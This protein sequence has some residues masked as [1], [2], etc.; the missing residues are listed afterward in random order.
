MSV[1]LDRGCVTYQ[2]DFVWQGTRYRG[3]THQIRKDDAELVEAQIKLKLRQ[4][5]G[6]IAPF[7]P[8]DTPRFTDWAEVYLAYQKKH[9]DRP[10]TIKRTLL[11]VLEFWGAKPRTAKRSPAVTRARTVQ[12]PYHNLHL[13]H[14]IADPSWLLRFERWIEAR[15]VSTSTRN[16]YLSA[17]S[18]MYRV[19]MQPEYR[20]DTGITEN[21]FKEIRRGRGHSREV[22]LDAQTIVRW[23]QEAGYHVALATTIAALAPKLRLGTIL[24]LRWDEHIDPNLRTITV[25]RHKTSRRTGRPQV[26]PISEQLRVVLADARERQHAEAVRRTRRRSRRI[27]DSG[28]VVTWRGRPV[29]SIKKACRRAVERIGLTWGVRDGV[30]FHTIRHSIATL[31][32]EMGLPEAIRKELL[33]HTEIRTTQRYTHLAAKA[34]TAPHEQLSAQLPVAE[35]LLAKPRPKTG[36]VL[37]MQRRRTG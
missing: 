34:Q 33:G 37:P 6:G 27:E 8:R 2:Y 14:P 25:T 32:A 30:T 29:A 9:T 3:T 31:L 20:K 22:A 5:A 15:R 13:G 7:D 10:D 35:T 18:G 1:Y 28:H 4:H 24:A 11:V 12:A 36:R 21:P 19:A 17:L 26:T 16:T 23:V